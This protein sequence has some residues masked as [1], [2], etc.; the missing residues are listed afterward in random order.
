MYKIHRIPHLINPFIKQSCLLCNDENSTSPF[1]G[2]NWKKERSVLNMLHSLHY[3]AL[4]KTIFFLFLC[5][6]QPYHVSEALLILIKT[7]FDHNRKVK[8]ERHA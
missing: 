4:H 8:R 5:K 6:K 7:S 1:C 3:T 2:P